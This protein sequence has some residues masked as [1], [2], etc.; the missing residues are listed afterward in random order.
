MRP[1]S[2][3]ADG[4]WNTE[5]PYT[6]VPTYVV[7]TVELSVSGRR[8]TS[9]RS[10]E[11]T[12]TGRGARRRDPRYR[13]TLLAYA[14]GFLFAILLAAISPFSVGLITFR[15]SRRRRE[16]YCGHPRLAVCVWLCVCLS[17]VVRPHYS[18][19][20]DVTWGSGCPLVVHYWADSQSGHGLRWYGNI[21]RTRN[22]SE[23]TL[24][25][26]LCLVVIGVHL[27]GHSLLY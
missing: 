9:S 26:V 13:P 27:T 1:A 15:V 8:R 16:M 7:I 2:I 23:Y 4:S 19:D 21:T 25:L 11:S 22:V 18:T 10:V 20:P 17:T 3:G 14:A 5:F 6:V 24:V 12:S